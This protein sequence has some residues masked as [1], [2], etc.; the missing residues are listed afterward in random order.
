MLYRTR[1]EARPALLPRGSD[2]PCQYTTP[3]EALDER[4]D[5]TKTIW[6]CAPVPGPPVPGRLD[7][8][9]ST[10]HKVLTRYRVARLAWLDR[11]TAAPIRRYEHPRPGDLVHVNVKKLGNIPD[12]GGWRVHGRRVGNRN[13][14]RHPAAT[15]TKH[16]N[17][18]LGYSYLHTALDD[19][20]RLAYTEILTDEGRD[21]A[22][23][24]WTRAHAYFA[25]CG[26]TV[27]RVLT[28]NASCYRSRLWRATPAAAGITVD[29][30]GA[31]VFAHFS[32]ISASGC[33]SLD[34]NQKV[35]FDITQGQKGP[36]AQNIRP[37]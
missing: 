6:A 1:R 36:Q 25:G 14:Q 15:R 4:R 7:L 2:A 3:H 34:E 26:I 9:A 5:L 28:D 13:C 20:S 27:R 10:V 17:P 24:F 29:G 30:G 8:A 11:T 22:V 19:H 18:V 37:L 16:H 12:G 23:A 31:D 21:T 32:A 35:E 33:R